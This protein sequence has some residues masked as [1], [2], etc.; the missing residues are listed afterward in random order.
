MEYISGVVV[1][2]P[3][4]NAGD[5]SSILAW[6]DPLE[7]EMATYSSILARKI[8]WTGSSVHGFAT[9]RAQLKQLNTFLVVLWLGLCTFTV[10]GQS[11]IPGVETKIPQAVW[12]SQKKEEI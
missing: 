4:A 6:E 12:H 1:K 3:P 10:E 9:S 7:E 5:K 11:L 2:N 8:P